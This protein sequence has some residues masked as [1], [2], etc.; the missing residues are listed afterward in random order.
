MTR[1]LEIDVAHF[2]HL[3]EFARGYLHQDMVAEHGSPIA[4]ARA[5][6]ADLTPADRKQLSAEVARFREM[7]AGFPLDAINL[8]FAKLG[9]AARFKSEEDVRRTLD[10]L[11]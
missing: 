8:V 11:T 2:P 5:Y 1:R 6:V 7:L 3:R 9:A 4:A 10:A